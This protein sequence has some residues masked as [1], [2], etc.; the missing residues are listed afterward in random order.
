V[1]AAQLGPAARSRALSAAG[2]PLLPTAGGGRLRTQIPAL[3]ELEL[4]GINFGI[5]WNKFLFHELCG[6]IFYSTQPIA[7]STWNYVE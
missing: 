2:W 5:M 1:R 7:Y 4:F 3:L 6:I